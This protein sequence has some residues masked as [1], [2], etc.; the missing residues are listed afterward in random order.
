MN[1][2]KEQ[3][4]PL[5]NNEN[6]YTKKHNSFEEQLSKLK[7]RNLIITNEE[8]TLSKLQHINYYRLSAYF[9]PYQYRKDST[10]KDQFL[11]DTSFEDIV[12][13][14]YF[15]SKLRTIIFEAIEVIEIYLRTQIAYHHSLKFGAFG[16]LYIATLRSKHQEIFDEL[17][18]DILQEKERSKE[19]FI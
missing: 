2:L 6:Q 17:H 16:Y 11:P 10:Q 18:H 13:L 12:K 19:V 3:L 1:N 9:L 8:Y 4:Q 5:K 7:S 14:Y 15:D